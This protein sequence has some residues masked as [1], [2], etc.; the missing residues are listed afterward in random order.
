MYVY[1]Y[2]HMYPYEIYINAYNSSQ[3]PKQYSHIVGL[4]IKSLLYSIL[5]H[6][7]PL[8]ANHSYTYTQYI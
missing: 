2:I 4:F 3:S 5:Y 1:K 6:V 7:S 8:W